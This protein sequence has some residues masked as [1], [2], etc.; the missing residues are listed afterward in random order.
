MIMPAHYHDG[1]GQKH[2]SWWHATA[3]PGA[4]EEL[5]REP[6]RENM[7]V[8]VCIVGAGIAGLSIADELMREGLSVAVVDAESIGAGESGRTTAHLASATDDRYSEIERMHG[9]HGA[10]LVASS[11]RAAIDHIGRRSADERIDCDFQHVD[12]Y[13]F[14]PASMDDREEL[15]E[16]EQDAASRAG[17]IDVQRLPSTPGVL[18]AGP[19]LR[20]GGQA[21]F[22]PLRYLAGL[23]RAIES[24]GGRIFTGSRAVK[25][26]GGTD[27]RIE[28]EHG[29]IVHASAIVVATNTPVND[30]VALHTKQ[31]ACRS[32]VVALE[33]VRPGSVPRGL[34]WDG[35][36]PGQDAYHYVRLDRQDARDVLIVG[37]ED[38]K[39]GQAHDQDERFESLIGWARSH[40]DG[41]GVA[42]ERWSGQII[43]PHDGVA[44]IGRNPRDH[45]N[46]Y[47]VT[48]DSGN[49]LTHGAIAGMLITDLIM[50]RDNAWADLYDP[51]RTSVRATG[52][53][54]RENANMAAQYVDWVRG[55]DV[56]S[57]DDIAPGCGAVVRHGLKKI[58][59][60]REETGE[61]VELSAVC[62]HLGG[63]VRWN[64]GEHTW[65]CPCHG[66]RFDCRGRVINGPAI[67]GLHEVGTPQFT[68]ETQRAGDETANDRR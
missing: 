29:A 68:A 43:E 52:E 64:P 5:R 10:Q 54:A 15:L 45:D 48:G 6:L 33:I 42:L 28:T 55:G 35:F 1:S 18:G 50:G 32:Y 58:A 7:R 9:T 40:F 46:V 56:A 20:F 31:A 60:Y 63:I 24:R 3:M 16:K 2:R 57:T 14:V 25:F 44:F 38:H 26:Q 61:L 49:G 65:D 36:W 59:A 39:T 22:H 37:G 12:G 47:I 19:C 51:R 53:F 66:S 21:Q 34:Y 62:P 8:D 27:A 13:L 23:A 30:I 41:L 17:L 4:G 67:S 11:H